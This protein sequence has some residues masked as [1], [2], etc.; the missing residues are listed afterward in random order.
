MLISDWSSDVCSS[1]LA[2][3][4]ARQPL[5]VRQRL[6]E[7][8]VAELQQEDALAQL[9]I[10]GRDRERPVQMIRRGPQV[11]LA[12]GVPPG[13]IG[14]GEGPAPAGGGVPAEQIGRASCRERVGQYV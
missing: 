12:L 7:P 1:D 2:V 3:L 10:L 5:G 6:V 9:D 11:E 13:E 8:A 4:C 14:A